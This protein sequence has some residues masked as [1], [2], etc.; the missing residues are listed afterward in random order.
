MKRLGP[1]VSVAFAL[2][3][4]A[5]PA[6]AQTLFTGSGC[7]GD[8]FS[9][10]ASWTGTYIDA[11]HFSLFVIN[12]SGVGA[13]NPLSAFTTV[14]VG[15]VSVAD[16]SSMGAVTGWQNDPNMSGFSGAGLLENQFGARTTNGVLNALTAGNSLTYAY[17]F[18]SSIGTFAQA[19][20]SFSGAQIAIIDYGTPDGVNAISCS[21]S[22][23]VF[24]ASSTGAISSASCSAPVSTVPEPGTA[25]M[26]ATGLAGLIG[27][28]RRRRKG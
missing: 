5:A 15:D 11:T 24:S 28:A 14:G 25:A 2:A 16:P 26:A 10:C 7:G 4:S 20:T 27:F 21:P 13:S 3:V 23:G 12:T 1:V 9:F 18:G 8:L 19:Q 6:G 17:T 22:R